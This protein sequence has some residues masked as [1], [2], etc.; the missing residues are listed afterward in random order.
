MET[1]KIIGADKVI[2]RFLAWPMKIRKAQ[3]QAMK[4]YVSDIDK[5]AKELMRDSPG[6]PT[7][8]RRKFGTNNRIHFAS[9]P[10]NPPRTETGRMRRTFKA[11]TQ[12]FPNQVWG[13]NFFGSPARFLQEGARVFGDRYMEARPFVDV[14][15]DRV[16]ANK[17]LRQRMVE[18]LQ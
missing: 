14:A 15:K 3:V 4:S 18:V 5:M 11:W 10:G 1:I 6:D 7:R 13:F 17:T 12:E 9:F 2:N 8:P 16:D